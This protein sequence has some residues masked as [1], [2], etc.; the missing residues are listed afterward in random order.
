MLLVVRRI[1]LLLGNDVTLGSEHLELGVLKHLVGIGKLRHA[2]LDGLLPVRLLL[3]HHGLLAELALEL[4]R[5][6]VE[7]IVEGH[8]LAQVAVLPHG[9]AHSS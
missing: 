2:L 4:R 7:P 3:E 5:L 1:D 6:G 8:L 9:E